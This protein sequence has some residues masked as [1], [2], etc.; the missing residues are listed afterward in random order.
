MWD[1]LWTGIGLATA[2]DSPDGFG[3]VEAGAIAFKD[4]RI[5]WVGP[6]ASLPGPKH[7]LAREHG[8]GHGRLMTPGLIDAHTHLVFGGDR[9]LDFD[10][11][12]QGRSYAEISAQGGGIRSTVRATR[13]LSVEALCD[14]ARARAR[15]RWQAGVTTLEVKSGYGLD[16]AP[17]LKRLRAARALAESLDVEIR[18][19]LL[20]LHALPDERRHE[21]ARYVDEVIHEWIPAVAAEGLAVAVDV[22]CEQIAFTPAECRRVLAAATAAGLATKVHADQL[23]DLGGAALAAEFGA[24]SADHLEYTSS[25]G[26]EALA[27]SK[28]VA[29]LLPG[30]YLML[31]ERQTPPVAA[32]RAHQVPMAIAT[33]LNPGTSP[34]ASLPLAATLARAQFGLTAAE[35]FHG[36]TRH[37]ARALGLSD[38]GTL[39][40]GQR[41]DTCLWDIQH[42]RELSY[43]LGRPLCATVIRGGQIRSTTVAG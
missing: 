34:L 11:R 14:G 27:R 3:Y 13:S 36:I 23:S 17:E 39:A 6:E 20:P 12:T 9:A 31:G 22:F 18:P 32:L 43:W 38:R 24:L 2:T 33:D 26:V 16:L 41:A 5:A 35:A 29:T 37:A 42:P 21:R 4:G 7:A 10:L 40:V 28:T 19:T 1:W 15:A 30:A 8:D 25:A